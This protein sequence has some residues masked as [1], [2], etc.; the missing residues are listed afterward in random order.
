MTPAYLDSFKTLEIWQRI[1]RN[2][3][4]IADK[5]LILDFNLRGF[6]KTAEQY[7]STPVLKTALAL[8]IAIVPGDDSHGV[9]SVGRNYQR[10]IELLTSLGA[11]TNWR[12]PALIQ[13]ES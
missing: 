10:G 1:E 3:G 2:L 7:P 6:D 4:F 13:Y 9:N 8:G 11:D 12:K 5:N